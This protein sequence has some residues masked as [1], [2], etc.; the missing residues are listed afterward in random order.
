MSKRPFL[1]RQFLLSIGS[2][3]PMALI[4]MSGDFGYLNNILRTF[5]FPGLYDRLY[6][7]I[8][9]ATQ[10]KLIALYKLLIAI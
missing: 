7:E 8:I 3:H 9:P 1:F 10:S 6:K 5:S 4:N 2:R